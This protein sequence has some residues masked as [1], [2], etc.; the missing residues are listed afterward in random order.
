MLIYMDEN[1]LNL[2][3]LKKEF[4]QK[5]S[6]LVKLRTKL[7]SVN[8]D[9]EEAYHN[10]RSLRDKVRSRQNHIKSFNNRRI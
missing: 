9:K 10:L 1:N 4:Q 6:E 7:N 2:S 8:K 3:E 5:K